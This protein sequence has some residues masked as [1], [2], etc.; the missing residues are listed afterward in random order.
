MEEKQT[1]LSKTNS[2]QAN[3]ANNDRKTDTQRETMENIVER[4]NE[5]VGTK[6]L[7][8]S[9]V[10]FYLEMCDNDM[11]AAV[12]FFK[13]QH[14]LGV[15]PPVSTISSTQ[16]ISRVKSFIHPKYDRRQRSIVS[17]PRRIKSFDVAEAPC[18]T[19]P[20]IHRSDH[21]MYQSSNDCVPQYPPPKFSHRRSTQCA[22][23][24]SGSVPQHGPAQFSHRRA[25][26]FMRHLPDRRAAQL[27]RSKSE[28]Q[29][30]ESMPTQ[31]PSYRS[32]H[33][34]SISSDAHIRRMHTSMKDLYYDASCTS[35]VAVT[36]PPTVRSDYHRST[37]AGV[38]VDEYEAANT[39]VPQYN[40]AA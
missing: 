14:N 13:D 2:K 17:S 21:T 30:H 9:V 5:A 39:Q 1:S 22:R 31:L 25:T 3:I 4:F 7:E 6:T 23:P 20:S 19:A 24:F 37:S 8:M 16:A 36:Q 12:T 10:Q 29:V 28:R 33:Q 35:A 34:R 26:Q 15:G 18:I 32:G 38:I 11:D 40:P 27:G